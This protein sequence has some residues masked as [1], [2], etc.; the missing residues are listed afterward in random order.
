M[1]GIINV[2]T[3]DKVKMVCVG[4]KCSKKHQCLRYK[5]YMYGTDTLRFI[6][7]SVNHC[8]VGSDSKNFIPIKEIKDE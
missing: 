8:G 5:M 4:R 6:P 7:T 1:S 3:E 2:I